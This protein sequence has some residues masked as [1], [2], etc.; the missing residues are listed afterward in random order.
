MLDIEEINDLATEDNNS[1][2]E[3]QI[4]DIDVNAETVIV[5]K[6]LDELD[7][8][9]DEEITV[10]ESKTKDVYR[11]MNTNQLKQLV[12]TKGLS[13]NPSKLKKNE[14]LQLLENSD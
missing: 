10:E 6:I 1:L 3:E 12:I 2:E 9:V 4:V 13:T 8:N 5:H 11:N 7:K 14:L